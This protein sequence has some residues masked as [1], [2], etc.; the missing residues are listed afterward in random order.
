MVQIISSA[1]I[2]VIFIILPHFY[3]TEEQKSK[4]LSKTYEGCI[5]WFQHHWNEVSE[6][7]SPS[8]VKSVNPN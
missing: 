7:V 2:L 5:A 6:S 4:S 8:L 1:K 3:K